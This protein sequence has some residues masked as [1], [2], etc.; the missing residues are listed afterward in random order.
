[1][2]VINHTHN[3]LELL[4]SKKFYSQTVVFKCFYWFT[5]DYQVSIK[6]DKKEFRIELQGNS[7]DIDIEKV[8]AKINQDL[9]DFK[10]RMIVDTETRNIRELIAAKAFSNY[11]FEEDENAAKSVMSDKI[12][13]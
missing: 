8:I 7:S 6:E 4:L 11:T 5:K 12:G 3:S 2:Q 10:L 9:I 13:F 1:M